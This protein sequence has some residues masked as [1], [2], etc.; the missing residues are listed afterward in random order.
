MSRVRPIAWLGE[1]E[2][3]VA[4]FDD[5]VLAGLAPELAS[6]VDFVRE[7]LQL[8]TDSFGS[9]AN[10]RLEPISR[11]SP[12]SE[13]R[14]FVRGL[15][16][17]YD[18]EFDDAQEN[19]KRLDLQRRPSRIARALTASKKTVLEQSDTPDAN[20]KL[21]DSDLLA[22]ANLV[23]SV[24]VARPAVAEAAR[25]L[26]RRERIPPEL[27]R[28]SLLGPE[29]LEWILDFCAQYRQVEPQLVDALQQAA[30]DRAMKQPFADINQIATAK[31]SGPPHDPKNLL[32]QSIYYG[33]F[34]GGEIKAESFLS[35]YLTKSL[36]NNEMISPKLRSAI[37][38][39]LHL[40]DARNEA[41]PSYG[42]TIFGRFLGPPVDDKAVIK[43]YKLALKAYPANAEAHRE[44]V[45]WIRE[46]L[47]DERIR[48]SLREPFEK[49]IQPAMKAWSDGVPDEIEPRLW[50]VD[51][52][53]E[54]E[55]L[56][57][58]KP[59]VQW[60]AGSRHPDPRV[61]ATPWKWELLEAMRL[62][63]RK[64]WLSHAQEKLDAAEKLWPTWLSRDWLAYLRAALMLR[65]NKTQAYEAAR[66][67]IRQ[68]RLASGRPI[69]ELTDAVMMLG[70][71]QHMR[72]PAAEL[73]SL[74]EPIDAA[75]KSVANLDFND[76]VQTASFFWDLY[77]TNMQYPAYRMHGGKFATELHR[78]LQSKLNPADVTPERRSNLCDAIY[79]LSQR[80]VFS[81]GYKFTLPRSLISLDEPLLVAVTT[82]QCLL[83]S[84]RMMRGQLQKY[85]NQIRLLRETAAKETD[86]YY[87]YWFQS[88][89]E[90]A[91]EEA[92]KNPFGMGRVGSIDP[93]GWN[94]SDEDDDEE[95]DDWSDDD[96]DSFDPECDCPSCTAARARAGVPLPSRST[97]RGESDRSFAAR[98]PM[99]EQINLPLDLDP[100][101]PSTPRIDPPI[102]PDFRRTRPKNPM[103]T[104][105]KKGR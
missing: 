7:A 86:P 77:R 35:Q 28:I 101:K 52:Y 13:W 5:Q 11:R 2:A 34:E 62:C 22:A 20:D 29:R 56:E 42:D 33:K 93:F 81:D 45:D 83:L 43:S 70:A 98:R 68:Q 105:R 51:H 73:K 74:R 78:R 19:W 92:A 89:A 100:P 41:K 65:Q 72:V 8:V 18:E 104:K 90:R 25:E 88:L 16:H 21:L 96:E 61:R 64:T 75:V 76:L 40:E 12:L 23:H 59:H 71:A 63:R 6:E 4:V 94:A 82:V 50:L 85:S 10:K 24:R 36:P 97:N 69:C 55:Q 84:H 53:L 66:I 91:S 31:I 15:V 57:E 95:D 37:E 30:L 79:W 58:A 99:N 54:N 44:Y 26:N 32:S 3:D 17:W 14:L 67:D 102:D 1:V 39:L 87:R 38:S 47:D 80:R 9:D 49:L 48:K 46:H 27:A 60:L 103:D